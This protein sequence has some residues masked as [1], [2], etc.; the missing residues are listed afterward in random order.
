MLIRIV[1]YENNC[2]QKSNKDYDA[3]LTTHVCPSSRYVG[4]VICAFFY[5]FKY[6][7]SIRSQKCYLN[8]LHLTYMQKFLELNKIPWFLL[9][10]F[11]K[12]NDALFHNILMWIFLS[13]E[14]FCQICRMGIT[15]L[16]KSF[17]LGVN[18]NSR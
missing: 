2:I 10:T 15:W 9:H 14:Y 17:N 12:K 4:K 7:K 11:S 1:Y 6:F 3:T 8:T 18:F 16:E 13:N 5:I